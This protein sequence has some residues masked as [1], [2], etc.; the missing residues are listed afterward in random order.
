MGPGAVRDDARYARQ[1]EQL[2]EK[3]RARGIGDLQVLHAVS[4]VPR[5]LFV[6]EGVR[7]RA[8]EDA[9][10]PIGYGQTISQP[11]IQAL[12]LEQLRLQPADRVLEIGTG[13][14]YQTALLARLATHVYSVE[15]VRE[16]SGRARGT[17]EG[18]GFRNVA[19][20]VGDGSVGW[21]RFAP[22]DAIVVTAGAPRVPDALLEQLGPGG[23]LLAPVGGRHEQRLVRVRRTADGFEQETVTSCVFVPLV[24][25]F[26]W[27]EGAA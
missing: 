8:Y 3:L 24:G 2:V 10:L 15:R 22:F 20:L 27:P 26:G 12:Y 13:S 9:A 21:S 16:L 6:P 1:R 23:R 25:R 4:E 14:G 18:L 11:S 17:L 5:H 19:L 7:H